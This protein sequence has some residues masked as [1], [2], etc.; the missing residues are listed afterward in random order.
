MKKKPGIT[1]PGAKF[2]MTEDAKGD[3]LSLFYIHSWS[4][5]GYRWKNDAPKWEPVPYETSS[6]ILEKLFFGEFNYESLTKELAAQLFPGSTDS[7]PALV[8]E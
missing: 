8:E 5:D 6:H 7:L 3:P 1:L 2:I 4:H